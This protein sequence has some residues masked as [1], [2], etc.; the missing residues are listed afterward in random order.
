MLDIMYQADMVHPVFAKLLAVKIVVT[1]PL[2]EN[3]WPLLA[4][5]GLIMIGALVGQME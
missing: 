3:V 2:A 4:N 1:I 5:P